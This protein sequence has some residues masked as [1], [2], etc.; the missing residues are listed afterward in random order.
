MLPYWMHVTRYMICKLLSATQTSVC[1]HLQRQKIH[2]AYIFNNNNTYIH[3][4]YV[5]KVFYW[6]SWTEKQCSQLYCIYKTIH[7]NNIPGWSYWYFTCTLLMSH[8]SSLISAFWLHHITCMGSISNMQ[9]LDSVT[10]T[11]HK[12][13]WYAIQKH[14]GYEAKLEEPNVCLFYTCN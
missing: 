3:L 9:L 1:S 6:P 7:L 5:S 12:K 11:T 13:Y 8:I 2:D 4:K 14:P 10:E